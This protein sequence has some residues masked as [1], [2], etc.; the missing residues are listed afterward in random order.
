[1]T[2]QSDSD[3]SAP[4]VFLIGIM[5]RAGT[6]YFADAL[7]IIDPRL[8]LPRVLGEDFL[9]E[10]S[11]LLVEYAERVR[12][13]WAKLPWIEEP[14]TLQK[15]LLR[16]LG[17]GLLRL[18]RQG[19]DP[20]RR[21]LA[22]T[23]SA[24][25]VDKFFDLFPDSRLLIITRDGR[26]AVASATTTFDYA[27]FEWWVREWATGA[28]SILDFMSGPARETRGSAWEMVRYEDVLRKDPQD[29]LGTVARVLDVASDRVEWQLMRDLPVRGS[30]Q[31]LDADGRVVWRPSKAGA[32]FNPI[33]RWSDWNWRQRRQFNRIAGRALAALGY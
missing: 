7:K 9:L 30:S 23:P 3:N 6:N 12:R 28:Q 21:L 33:G 8:S 16:E 1:M 4:A 27:P 2:Q 15:E 24:I 20:E 26:D 14:T 29:A 5:M 22:K 10:H 17:D 13:R 11:N 19:M 32:D 18:L 31:V 25:N